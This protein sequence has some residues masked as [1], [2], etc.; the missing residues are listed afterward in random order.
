MTDD[1]I[2]IGQENEIGK[3]GSNY[4]KP[5]LLV[6]NALGEVMNGTFFGG[7]GFCST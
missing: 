4:L 3:P 6:I 1:V 5:M 7:V 2:V